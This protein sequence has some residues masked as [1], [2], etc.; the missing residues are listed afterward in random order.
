M[1]ANLNPQPID[2]NKARLKRFNLSEKL[3]KVVPFT[4]PQ[5]QSPNL[6]FDWQFYLE[7]HQD[8]KD[9]S[10][11]EAA[12]EHWTLFGAAEGRLPNRTV[13]EQYFDQK[14]AELPQDFNAEQYLELNP[15][16]QRRFSDG[17]YFRYY[18][19]EHYLTHGKQEGRPYQLQV[20]PPSQQTSLQRQSFKSSIVQSGSTSTL[21]DKP[22]TQSTR[23]IAF[24]LP[25]FHP[26][27]ENDRWWGK[28]FTEW[29]NVTKAKPLF[30]GHYQPHLPSDLGFYDLRL[31]EVREMQAELARNYGIYGFCY[32]Y[33]WFA[34]KRLLNRPLDDVLASKKP[35]FPFCICW[36]NENWT[37]R[38]DGQEDEVLIAQDFSDEQNRSFAESVIPIL[39]DERYIRIN[40]KPLLIVYRADIF[41]NPKNTTEQWREIFRKNGVGEVY[42]AVALTCFS[43]L[44]SGLTD[45]A[46]LG[47][48]AG[49][50]FAP[51]EISAPE[52]QPEQPILSDFS[53]KFYDYKVA[54]INAVATENP[55]AKVFLSAMPSWDNT[56]RRKNSAHAFLNSNPQDYE[57]WLRGAIEKTRQRHIGDEQ[58]VFINAWNEWA[59][60]AHL[61]PDQKYGHDF[62]I[63][64]CQALHGAHG[65][66]TIINLLRY[67][68]LSSHEHLCELLEQLERRIEKINQSLKVIQS[69]LFQ[70]SATVVGITRF[71]SESSV[72]WNL[73]FPCNHKIV[74]LSSIELQGWAIG[75]SSPIRTMDIRCNNYLIAQVAVD[76]VRLDVAQH[77]SRPD[78]KR[79]GF[80]VQVSIGKQ[81]LQQSELNLSVT[82]QNNRYIELGAVKLE[83]LQRK[84]SVADWQP[85]VEETLIKQIRALQMEDVE[86]RYQL[87]EKLDKIISEKDSFIKTGQENLRAYPVQSF[88]ERF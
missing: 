54:A 88:F 55:Q 14:K 38:W 59:E 7:Y 27:P 43:G 25:Q 31:P 39:Q 6:E 81:A 65:W 35:D 10:D 8:L 82:L 45:P 87:I 34:G 61:E 76:L 4:Q 49:V 23:L 50:Q 63:A 73:D 5:E 9:L 52:T 36:A 79:C 2:L 19:V 15:D 22:Q 37:R 17:E 74:N 20:V 51:H 47:F 57:F 69:F 46:Q 64:T 67:L 71:E 84:N 42:L 16:L 13:L 75:I 48:D 83:V 32:Y 24:Y 56:A 44:L 18:A 53:G 77:L 85:D 30:E 11:R 70:N 12:Y 1:E 66:K 40:G 80:Y 68:P 62:L 78:A 86:Q 33:Y 60:G 72:L 3:N 58:L 28:G 29:T 41:P 26:I 21:E